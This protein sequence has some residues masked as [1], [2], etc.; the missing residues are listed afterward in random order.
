MAKPEGAVSTTN[1]HSAFEKSR[2]FGSVTALFCTVLFE[3]ILTESWQELFKVTPVWLLLI[4]T[5][6]VSGRP[7]ILL[8]LV[9]ADTTGAME[10]SHNVWGSEVI[11]STLPGLDRAVIEAPYVIPGCPYG[12]VWFNGKGDSERIWP[13]WKNLELFMKTHKAHS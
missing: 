12:M 11:T 9:S 4:G 3:L 6:L 13:E 2:I 5:S 7:A 1:H 8:W 10:T